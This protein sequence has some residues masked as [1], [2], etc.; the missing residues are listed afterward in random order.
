MHA[1]DAAEESFGRPFLGWPMP[2]AAVPPAPRGPATPAPPAP[3]EAGEEGDEAYRPYLLT[4]GRTGGGRAGV[5]IETLL[6]RDYDVPAIAHTTTPELVRIVEACAGPVAV[7]EV[8]ARL[9]LPVGVVQVLAG[10]LVSAGVLQ[11]STATTSL[12]DDVG[13]IERLIQGVA[14][15]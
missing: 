4:G 15:L 7:A 8:A 6:V 10:D 12:A 2:A 11:R 14:S 13:F 9:G 3:G 1:D 5:K